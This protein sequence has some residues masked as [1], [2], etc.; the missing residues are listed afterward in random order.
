MELL[1]VCNI[2]HDVNPEK[3]NC[4]FRASLRFTCVS[5]AAGKLKLWQNSDIWKPSLGV[6]VVEERG[7]CRPYSRNLNLLLNHLLKVLLSLLTLLLQNRDTGTARGQFIPR[8]SCKRNIF[9]L[10]RVKLNL[11]LSEHP[12]WWDKLQPT[13]GILLTFLQARGC[14]KVVLGSKAFCSLHS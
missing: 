3:T 11:Q 4:F 13:S 8:V 7:V 10:P 2:S 9:K 5:G 14:N 12:V 6:A 1:E